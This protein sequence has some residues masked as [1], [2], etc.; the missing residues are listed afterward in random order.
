MDT[1]GLKEPIRGGQ[2]PRDKQ[3]QVAVTTHQE[4]IVFLEPS[5][6][7]DCQ[8]G[9][10]QEAEI[11]EG[12]F[13]ARDSVVPYIE[14]GENKK[15]LFPITINAWMMQSSVM[16]HQGTEKNREGIGAGKKG[17]WEITRH[18]LRDTHV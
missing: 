16:R 7:K 6:N 15:C 1:G 3:Q 8:G 17:A 14:V 13:L 5:E 4:K 10:V 12:I 18:T 11:K 9:D 2:A